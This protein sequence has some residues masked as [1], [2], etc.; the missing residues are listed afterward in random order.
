MTTS[1][2]TVLRNRLHYS[3]AFYSAPETHVLS[4]WTPE[5]NFV[6]DQTGY[7]YYVT[8]A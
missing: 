1:Y 8:D 4:F 2:S 7:H 5:E 6:H 3:L